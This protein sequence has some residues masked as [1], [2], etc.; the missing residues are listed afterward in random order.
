MNEQQKIRKMAGL[1][2][3]LALTFIF[4]FISNYVQVGPVSINLTLLPIAIA[5]IIYGPL[6]GMVI[7]FLSGLVVLLSPS[8]AGFMSF[9]PW[10][11]IIVVLVKTSVAGLIS[12]LLFRLINKKS[13]P[14]AIIISSIVVPLINTGIFALGSYLFF[15]NFLF[16][17]ITTNSFI[18][19][20][21]TIV[22][23]NFIFEL[24]ASIILSPTLVSVIKVIS[25]RN[26][27]GSQI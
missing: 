7:G 26:N 14:V 20:C 6:E 8:T 24:S 25:K 23:F 16:A 15:Y 19:F 1:G 9:N 17:G 27:I 13:F 2:I 5:A 12:G 3:L 10:G 21:L 4:G 22:G 18:Y 11:T